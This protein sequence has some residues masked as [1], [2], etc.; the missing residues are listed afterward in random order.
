MLNGAE[1]VVGHQASVRLS[2]AI[3]RRRGLPPSA[4]EVPGFLMWSKMTTALEAA[5]AEI[6]RHP[7]LRI[8]RDTLF[9]TPGCRGDLSAAIVAGRWVDPDGLG[10]GRLD[11]GRMHSVSS[12]DWAR[13]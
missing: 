5:G 11:L 12:S 6:S 2:I 13:C 10:R 1:P 7:L 9:G 4:A 3:R 8:P